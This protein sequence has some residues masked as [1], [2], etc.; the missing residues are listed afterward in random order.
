MI[1]VGPL[2][3]RLGIRARRDREKWVSA[4]PNPGHDDD[5]PSWSIIDQPG[6]RKHASHLCFGCDLRGGP[7]ELAAVVWGCSIQNAGERLRG[8]HFIFDPAST[9]TRWGPRLT[10]ATFRMSTRFIVPQFTSAWDEGARAYLVDR[11]LTESQMVRWGVGY[12]YARGR[13]HADRVVFPVHTRGRLVN[14]TARSFREHVCG[15]RERCRGGVQKYMTGRRTDGAEKRNALMG[16]QFL[17]ESLGVV[18]VTEGCFKITS[19]ERAGWPNVVGILGSNVGPLV[20]L[21][22]GQFPVVL[23]ATDPDPAGD[24]AAAALAVLSRRGTRV[25]RVR[26]PADPDEM[27]DA[28]LREQKIDLQIDN[29]IRRG[30]RPNDGTTP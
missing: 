21:R 12:Q 24:K 23:A 13:D 9:A 25:V 19:L 14:F 16:D 29:L 11:G 22:L 4:C 15:C 1:E 18:T 6:S 10:R 5:T 8:L 20:A 17:D 26:F 3:V 27:T 2:L 30:H 28:D 7:W